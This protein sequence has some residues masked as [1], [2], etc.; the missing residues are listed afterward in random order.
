V[1]EARCAAD[2]GY[3][4]RMM[5]EVAPEWT[6]CVLAP[7]FRGCEGSVALQEFARRGCCF[8]TNGLCELHGTPY[9]P[10]ECRFCHHARHGLGEKCHADIERDWQTPEGQTLVAAWIRAFAAR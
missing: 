3:G 5:L 7:A 4:P 2:A 9:M 6:H 1:E 10:L 8:L